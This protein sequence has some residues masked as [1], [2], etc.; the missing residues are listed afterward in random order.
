MNANALFVGLALRLLSRLLRRHFRS[1]VRL[2]QKEQNKSKRWSPKLRHSS[3]TKER[4]LSRISE[5]KT[6]RGST[7]TCISLSTT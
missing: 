3:M 5:R 4:Q 7:V 2:R 6:A 1:K